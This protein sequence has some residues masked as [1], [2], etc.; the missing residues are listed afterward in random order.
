MSARRQSWKPAP[1]VDPDV[2]LDEHY[3]TTHTRRDSADLTVVPP[4]P[5]AGPSIGGLVKAVGI[6]VLLLSI[7]P[8]TGALLRWLG[9]GG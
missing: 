4:L 8:A 6:G 3:G 5:E 1:A 7:W 2:F 9:S